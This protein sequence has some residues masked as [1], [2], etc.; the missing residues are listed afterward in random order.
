MEIGVHAA[1]V[2]N[3]L[4]ML[5]VILIVALLVGGRV[6]SFVLRWLIR[7]LAETAP[8]RWRLTILKLMPMARLAVALTVL[9]LIVPIVIQPTFQNVVTLLGAVGLALAFALKDFASSLVAGLVTVV[10]GLYQP[11]DWIEVEGTYGEVTAVGLRALRLVTLDDTEVIIPHAKLWSTSIFNAT[12]GNRHLLCVTHFYLDPHHDAARVRRGLEAVAA[13]SPYRWPDSAISVVVQEKPWGT[14]YKVKAYV[15]ESR[16]QVAFTSDIT[17]R[18][19]AT[20]QAMGI[21]A[22]RVPVVET[23]T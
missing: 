14:H 6:A 15:Q 20:L 19:K 11:G 13:E 17:V 2:L 16:D 10:E 23:G 12:S 8:A 7:H 21:K 4:E 18:G 9:A 5:D 22:A 1:K 3:R